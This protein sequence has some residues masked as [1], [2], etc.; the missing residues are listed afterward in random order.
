MDDFIEQRPGL[1]QPII[2]GAVSRGEGPTAFFA[3]VPPPSALGGDVEGVSDDVVFADLSIQA[4]IGVRAGAIRLL[5]PLHTCFMTEKEQEIQV[6]SAVAGS[7]RK[8]T[9]LA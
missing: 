5:A 6:E 8:S 3:T 7:S 1:M 9:T 4:A 2:R